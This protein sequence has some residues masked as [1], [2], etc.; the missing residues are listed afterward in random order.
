MCD[1]RAALY[2][3]E[4]SAV[5]ARRRQPVDDAVTEVKQIG[6]PQAAPTAST[7]VTDETQS[8]H[9][10][11]QY[12]NRPSISV[13]SFPVFECLVGHRS[14]HQHHYIIRRLTHRRAFV[15]HM[16]DGT[17]QVV[18]Q[19]S[20]LRPRLASSRKPRQRRGG[21][22]GSTMRCFVN[23]ESKQSIPSAQVQQQYSGAMLL[24]LWDAEARS[25]D[26]VPVA[27]EGAS[28][29][30]SHS[31]DPVPSGDAAAAPTLDR[32]EI[33][34]QLISMF[35]AAG[36]ELS[37]D[38]VAA[39]FADVVVSDDDARLVKY[40][41][42]MQSHPSLIS[43]QTSVEEVRGETGLSLASQT[44]LALN[45]GLGWVQVSCMLF[46]LFM[47]CLLVI[48][49]GSDLTITQSTSVSAEA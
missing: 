32:D 42:R 34:A 10:H 39:H 28:G 9:Y 47:L 6:A 12:L 27:T 13:G 46:E 1:L 3:I 8:R 49:A 33:A 7:P 25:A 43:A 2:A 15:Q 41:L 24:G 44:G 23:E 26:H 4:R 11:T 37:S 18:Q 5:E 40:V 17:K 30:V 20:H 16:K 22:A 36:M 35:A 31:A 29:H 38:D 45:G 14:M 19:Q 48:P 21:G